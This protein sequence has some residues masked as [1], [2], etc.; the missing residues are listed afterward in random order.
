MGRKSRLFHVALGAAILAVGGGNGVATAATSPRALSRSAVPE[1]SAWKRLVI[2]PVAVVYPQ[3][4]Q[5]IGAATAVAN[6][7]VFFIGA[8]LYR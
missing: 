4:V 8:S 6:S 3:S 5:V 7:D 1:S 2:D